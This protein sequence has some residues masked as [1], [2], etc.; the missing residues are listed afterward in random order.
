MTGAYDPDSNLI[1]WGTGNPAPDWNGDARAGDNLY[2]DSAIALDADTGELQWH[3]QFV[4]HDVHDWDAVQVPILVDDEREGAAEEARLLGSPR[5][6]LLRA[7]PTD[8]PVSFRD[9]V[10]EA[11][12]GRGTDRARTA[13]SKGR[14][15]SDRRRCVAV[16][17]RSRR[18]ELVLALL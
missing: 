11:N 15:R 18:H 13:D 3:F 6:V 4:P 12:L 1:L 5:R 8:G 10:R 17:G 16:A 7:R 9:S 2:S 14:N